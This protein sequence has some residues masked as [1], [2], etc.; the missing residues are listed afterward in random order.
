MSE[1]WVTKESGERELFDP[2]KALVALERAGLGAGDA[3][4]VLGQLESEIYDGISTK[5]IYGML[6]DLVDRM[7]PEVTHKFNL[8]RALMDIGPEG[9]DFEDFISKLLNTHGYDTLTRQT[10]QGKCV[11]HEIDVI[12]SKE[13]KSYMME[14]KFHN[15]PGARCRIQTILY[16]YARFL[17]LREGAKAG[18]CRSFAAP[19][20]VTN[21]KFSEDVITY[22]ECK[23]L[24]LLGWHYPYRNSLEA[25]IEKSGCYP[26]SVIKMREDTLRRLLKS[27]II[28][29]FDIPDSPQKLA[30]ASGISKAEAEEIIG[31]AEFAK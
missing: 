22:A 6:F 2:K 18:L 19:W 20:L 9:Y 28:T 3:K 21:T 27:K 5:K 24:P 11:T 10:L 30:G 8:K 14:C 31:R 16:V 23:G 25:M 26:V 1:I 12:A 29:V 13:R 4:E 7:R 15:Q 17:D